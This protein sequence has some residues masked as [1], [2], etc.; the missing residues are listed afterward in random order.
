MMRMLLRAATIAARPRSG[1]ALTAITVAIASVLSL[2]GTAYAAATTAA[3]SAG[4][5]VAAPKPARPL[6]II[7]LAPSLTEIAYAAG[8]G[9]QLVGVVEFSDYPAAAKSVPRVGDAWRVDAERVLAMRPDVVLVWPTGTPETTI[10]RLRSLGLNVVEVPTQSL[11]DV[12]HALR[13][14][15]RLAGTSAIAEQA[16]RDFERR[17]A[18]QRARFSQ[19]TPV[20]VFIQIDDDPV[21]TVNGRHVISEIVALCGGRNVFADLPQL[22]PAIAAEAVLAA[23]PQVIL[24]TDDTIANPRAFWERWPR[25]RA[26]QADTIF[27]VSSDLV[28]RAS[29]RLAQGVEV[30]C[31]TLERARARLAPTTAAQKHR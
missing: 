21:F 28:T 6:R 7:S 17:V 19:R 12:P 30:T 14:V 18:E 5:A 20:S 27:K 10:E 25:M 26:V 15:G 3:Q 11:A 24:S 9:S 29:P 1:V 8:A 23:D 22:A 16:A 2:T 4:P 31:S 13:Q